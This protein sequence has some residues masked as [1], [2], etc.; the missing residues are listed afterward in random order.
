MTMRLKTFFVETTFFKTKII[1]RILTIPL[2]LFLVGGCASVS[3][4]EA[5]STWKSYEEVGKWL[6]N[7]FIFDNDRSQRIV[8]RLKTQGPTGLLV[9][10]PEKLFKHKRGYCADATHFSI[11]TL[12]K[13]DPDYNARWVLI[14][15]DYGHPHHWVAA[16]DYEGK[17]YIMDYGAGEKWAAMKGIHGPYDSLNEYGD[18][19]D[20]LSI[21]GFKV[22]SV[23]YHDMP[24]SED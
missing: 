7:N 13:I 9:K 16:F 20:S 11:E 8:Y 23:Y 4:K 24:G 5:T 14:L 10:N 18:F 21:S 22:L 2:I 19:L 3:Y 15:N 17:L 6:D 1:A 12:N